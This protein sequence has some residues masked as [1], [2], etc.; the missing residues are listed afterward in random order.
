M[1]RD[2]N[3]AWLRAVKPPASGRLEVVDARTPGLVFRLTSAG[4]ASWV[5][6]GRTKDARQTRITLG[7]YLP[8]AKDAGMSLGEARAAAK[9]AA[10][11]LRKGADP[12]AEKRAARAAR[13]VRE[14]AEAR[15]RAE[16]EAMGGGP[17]PGSV[18]ARLAEW[19]ASRAGE[20]SPRYVAEVKRIAER[21]IIPALGSRLLTE[22]TR[23][24]WTGLIADWRRNVAKPKPPPRAGEKGKPGA[25]PQDGSGAA[26]FLYRTVSAFLNFAEVQGWI[27]APLL[28]R[29][30]ASLIAPAPAARARVLTDAELAAVWK[31]ADRESP[32]LR[33]FVRLLIL[34]GAR[35]LEVADVAAGELDLAAGRWTIPGERTKNRIGY[36]L[37]LSPLALAVLRAVWPAEEPAADHRL[38]GRAT[39][40]GFRGFGKL[41]AR[42]DAATKVAGWRWHDLRRTARTGMTRLGVPR[43][44]AEAAI[45][46]VSGRTKLE[47]TY[48]RHDYAPEVI[49]ALTLWQGHVAG[50]VG[51]AAEVVSLADRQGRRRA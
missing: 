20:W 49:A 22:T 11:D 13:L 50:L 41:K 39:G 10:A 29:K 9:D 25:S 34:T 5:F 7:R 28:P 33:A 31:A 24:D 4:A 3:D 18:A 16:A 17:L 38:L 27:A 23:A 47:R 15:A 37:P 43:D 45:N 8:G 30:G 12:V 26:A 44:H 2:L 6:R 40:S 42:M 32:K 48:D 1:K 14:A 46:H 19:Q 51:Q 35:E 21:A 36:T